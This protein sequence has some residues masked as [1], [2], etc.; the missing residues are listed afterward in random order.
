MSDANMK[1]TRWTRFKAGSFEDLFDRE[2]ADTLGSP[3]TTHAGVW[4]IRRERL[5]VARKR[6]VP[7]RH[8]RPSPTRP[9]L[10][11]PMAPQQRF[12]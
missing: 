12:P 4:G 6:H 11:L 5:H 3:W 8:A 9:L 10:V 7:A 1:T 2:Y